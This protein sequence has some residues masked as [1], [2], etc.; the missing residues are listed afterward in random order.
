ME[1]RNIF[2]GVLLVAIGGLFILD[3]LDLIN[4]SFSALVGLWP[5]LLVVWGIS[6]LP[7]KAVYKTVA[8][9]AIA[10]LALTYAS[11]SDKTFWWEDH[12]IDKFDH[13]NVHF[14]GDSDNSEESEEETFY[15][16][17]FDEEMDANITEAQL[18]MDVAAGK[19]R[20]D[21]T[22]EDHIIDFEAY[23]NFGPYTSNMVTNGNRADI[24]IGFD[25]AVIKSGT[26]RNRANVKLN[27]KVE[28]ELQ[29]NV[30]AADFR[31][32]FRNF[33]IKSIDLDGGASAIRIKLGELQKTTNIKIDAGA[34]SIK[35]DIPE[36]AGCKINTDSFLV[37]K[38]FEGFKKVESGEY[39]SYNYDESDQ[40]IYIDLDAA[41]SQ[42]TVR[43]YQP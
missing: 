21:G 3:N 32:D 20:I 10:V 22:T 35:I 16:F 29:L 2:W 11:T 38:D 31:G 18:N 15:T 5:L 27:P 39:V 1:N 7:L 28:W 8:G 4:F 41:I 6:I 36:G 42:L 12:V 19:F 40:K 33:K 37:D 43:R 23:S 30:G 13:A 17:Q 9:I 26:N 14:R 34:A 24:Q 25:D